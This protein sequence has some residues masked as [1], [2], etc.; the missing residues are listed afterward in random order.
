M[1]QQ[2]DSEAKSLSDASDDAL[3]QLPT[4]KRRVVIEDE[5]IYVEGFSP[6]YSDKARSMRL[7]MTCRT[8]ANEGCAWAVKRLGEEMEKSLAYY[9]TG[10]P[11][12]KIC[13]E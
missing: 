10:E 7:D 12:D 1:T 5:W 9:H 13:I 8:V 2:T 6:E 4:K 3:D 11:V